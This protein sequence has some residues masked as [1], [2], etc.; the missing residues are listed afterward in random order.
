MAVFR[1]V[2]RSDL[3]KP[4][5]VQQLSGNMFT[6][7][8]ASNEIAVE[9]TNGGEPVALS[10][11]VTAYAVRADGVTAMFSGTISGNVASVILPASCY[12]EV[13]TLSIVIKVGTTTV[14]A[15]TCYVYRTTTDE[16][17][18]PGHVI[19]SIEELLEQIEACR[20]ATTNANTA[21][22][23]ANAKATLAEN[24][25]TNANTKASV[26]YTAAQNANTKATQAN[27]AATNANTAAGKINNMTVAATGLPAG[28][29]PVA[30]ITEVDGHKHIAFQI[31]KG[32]KGKDFHIAKTFASISA[33]MAYTGTDLEEYDFAMIDTGSVEDPDTGKLYC[34][35]PDKNPKWSYI[36]DL[37][38]AQ[39]IKGETGNGIASAVLNSDYT[40]TLNWTNGDH[41]TTPSIR[42]EQGRQGET[43][44]TGP[45]GPTGSTGATPNISIGTVTDVPHGTP[46]SATMTG[47]AEN[48]VLN[49]NLQSGAS[50]NETIDDTAGEGDTDLVWSADKSAREVSDLKSALTHSAFVPTGEAYPSAN[51]LIN[52][53]ITVDGRM[54]TSNGRA[55]TQYI[56]GSRIG[57]ALSVNAPG[58]LF[59]IYYFTGNT[60][61]SFVKY[62]KTYY[63]C[64]GSIFAIPNPDYLY[65]VNFYHDPVDDVEFTQAEGENIANALILYDYAKNALDLKITKLSGDVDNCNSAIDKKADPTYKTIDTPAS[66]ITIED[67]ADDLPVKEMKIAIEPVQDLHGYE[68]PWPGGGGKNLLPLTVE[69]V[70]SFNTTGT[71]NGNGYTTTSGVKFTIISK[72]GISVDEIIANGTASSDATFHL[73]NQVN[74]API[75]G[76]KTYFVS[77]CP[78]GGGS[79]KYRICIYSRTDGSTTNRVTNDYGS[80]NELYSESVIYWGV[81]TIFN[82]NTVSNLSFRPMLEI[83]DSATSYA[84]YS[85][86][87]PISGWTGANVTRT[88]K[89]LLKNDLVTTRKNNVN[90]TKNEDGTV[91]VAGTASANTSVDIL[92]SSANSYKGFLKGTYIISKGNTNNNVRLSINMYNGT[93][94]IKQIIAGASDNVEY[95]IDYDGYDGVV[96][97]LYVPNSANVNETVMPM[98]RYASETDNSYA[99]YNGNVY[100]YTF[101]SEAGTVYSG[102]LT[103]NQ[104]GTGTLVVD[105][106]EIV[107][108]G[109]SDESWSYSTGG[110]AYISN[111]FGAEVDQNVKGISNM[112]KWN[113]NVKSRVGDLSLGEISFGNSATRYQINAYPG[114]IESASDFTAYLATNNLQVV[115]HLTTPITYTLT[116]PQVRT[117]LGL[118]KIWADTGDIES[119]TYPVDTV[120]ALDNQTAT[121]HDMIAESDSPVVTE[122]HAVGDVFICD[123]KLYKAKDAIAVG[124]NIIEGSNVEQTTV[125]DELNAIWGSIAT[126]VSF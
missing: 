5:V 22:S 4:L 120:I 113:N 56:N 75:D 43:G 90:F 17:V 86:I 124:E 7:D 48:P 37:S 109:S 69:G 76:T 114:G 47:T 123:N 50:G 121:T 27:S 105:T 97:S 29:A 12:V 108:D 68:N 65:R 125:A 91:A 16:I 80:G 98:I 87:C 8:N 92:G 107:Y 54:S 60:Q 72:D 70:K 15:C 58:Y 51:I 116:A 2:I 73:L 42:G 35:E 126:G 104:D 49:L 24:A 94:W 1:T 19:P 81:I 11:A 46:S 106:K 61:G 118:N 39:G 41:Y 122:N 101:P 40:L 21:A 34:Y 31:P 57:K 93:T 45:T 112:F 6:A 102:E 99:P 18:D 95:E 115:F 28:A 14:G 117:L 38:G 10:G 30:T 36:G 20:T 13:G 53:L 77:G 67:G 66:I 32:D 23:N 79:S 84:P 89:N 3:Q 62:D 119:I 88:G 85:N 100:S 26:A 33:M 59:R 9:V 44:P 82:G 83:N 78:S 63:P 52:T 111:A 110:R 71:W 74:A 64:D 103:I 25:A 55:C 96:V